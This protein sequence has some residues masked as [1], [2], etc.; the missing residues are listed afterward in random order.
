MPE[1]RIAIVTAVSALGA[2]ADTPP[3]RHALAEI[4]IASEHVAWDDPTVSWG[5]FDAA[6]LR[7]PWDYTGRRPAFLAWTQSAAAATRLIN[8]AHAIAWNTDKR[9]L[10]E[11]GASGVAVVESRFVAPD[12]PLGAMP[13]WTDFVIKPTV[14]AGSSGAARFTRDQAPRALAHAKQLQDGGAH[15]MLQPYLADVDSHGETALVYFD[16]RFSHAVGKAALLGA[17]GSRRCSQSHPDVIRATQA[18]P[19]QRALAEAALETTAGLLGLQAPLAYARVDLL[20]SP[21]GPRLLELE[22]TEPSVFLDLGDG[23]AGRMA[24]A[25]QAQL[26]G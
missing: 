3:L 21:D 24:R 1:A 12:E 15:L 22:L 5:R 7:S 2:D 18:Q 6:V 9:Y 10:A 26:R 17:D 20:P 16:G 23:A 19:A 25:I 4:G 13:D 11:L 14:G 8:P